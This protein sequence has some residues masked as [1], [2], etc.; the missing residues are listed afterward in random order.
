MPTAIAALAVGGFVAIGIH[1]GWALIAVAIVTLGLANILIDLIKAVFVHARTHHENPLLAAVRVIDANHR[2]YG[3]QIVHTGIV[4]IIAGVTGSSLFSQNET[5][6]LKTGATA[7]FAGQTLRLVSIEQVRHEN[8]T[9]VQANVTLTDASGVVRTFKPERRFFD[10]AEEPSSAVAIRSDLRRDYYLTLAGWED[11]GSTVAIQAIV[12]PLVA[13]IWVGGIVLGLGG[14]V[15]L[16][17]RFSRPNVADPAPV[18]SAQRVDRPRR[19]IK[20]ERI[21]ETV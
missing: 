7:S 20:Q 21:H 10:K 16:L 18:A 4:L 12:N 19:K 2:R 5:I 6:E 17:P 15:C 9:A 3:G 11:S 13:W 14:I 8:Y 1:N